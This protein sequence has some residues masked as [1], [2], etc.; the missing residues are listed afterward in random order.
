MLP[1]FG[2]LLALISFQAASVFGLSFSSVSGILAGVTMIGLGIYL[3]K[4]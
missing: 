2:I 1:I 3:G 4:R